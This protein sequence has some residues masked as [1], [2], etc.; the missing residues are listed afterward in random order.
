MVEKLDKAYDEEIL[1]C[2]SRRGG[3]GTFWNLEGFILSRPLIKLA[4]K[5]VFYCCDILN[6][7]KATHITAEFEGDMF[8]PALF[9][10]WV[11]FLIDCPENYDPIYKDKIVPQNNR[12]IK[13]EMPRFSSNFNN[14]PVAFY[15]DLMAKI[16]DKY[17]AINF[18]IKDIL[19][20]QGVWNKLHNSTGTYTN[21]GIPTTSNIS[22]TIAT[23]TKAEIYK[24]I[25]AGIRLTKLAEGSW[26]NEDTKQICIECD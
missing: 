19:T 6:E 26:Y 20:R 4:E 16:Y 3:P 13:F 7:N 17:K 2:I 25:N 11:C 9:S 15:K 5:F 1:S 14:D 10:V 18:T 24:M 12:L 21:I 8:D 22:N 23:Y